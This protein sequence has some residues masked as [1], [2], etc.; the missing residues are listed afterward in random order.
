[1]LLQRAQD[2]ATA[3]V[4]LPV[5]CADPTLRLSRRLAGPVRFET[6]VAA[7]HPRRVGAE[8]KQ[9]DGQQQRQQHHPQQEEE[10]A[11]AVEEE[12]L[13]AEEE[14][15]EAAAPEDDLYGDDLYGDLGKDDAADEDRP[16]E[17][18]E[19]EFKEDEGAHKEGDDASGPTLLVEP[20]YPYAQQDPS[21]ARQRLLS[22]ALQGKG[23]SS[24]FMDTRA[25][26]AALQFVS[27]D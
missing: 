6:L 17:D 2:L 15:E 16:E 26:V 1:M 23:F 9:E 13:P 3:S 21:L 22:R 24:I 27:F 18:K 20:P 11:V 7:R 14:E 4:A 8:A 12:E 25:R 5:P 10:A 19:D